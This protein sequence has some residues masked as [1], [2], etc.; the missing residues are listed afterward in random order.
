METETW[1]DRLRAAVENSGQSMRGV[2]LK[3]D[4]TPGYVFSILSE[5][6]DPSF[7]NLLKICAALDV[8]ALKVCFDLELTPELEEVVSLYR[9]ASPEQRSGILQILRASRAPLS[10]PAQQTVA[11]ESDRARPRKARSTR[12]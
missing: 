3:A 9:A 6:K 11:P 1:R 8:S 4:M 7:D 10:P 2:S 5:G 12:T